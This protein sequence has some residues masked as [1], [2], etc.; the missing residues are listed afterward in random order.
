MIKLGGHLSELFGLASVARAF[1]NKLLVSVSATCFVFPM[2]LYTV[3][4]VLFF[5]L[6]MSKPICRRRQFSA[7]LQS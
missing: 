2:Q 3:F 4:I 5:R 7:K 6:L 1:K